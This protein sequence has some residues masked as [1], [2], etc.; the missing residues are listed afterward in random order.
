ML[1][2]SMI[3]LWLFARS[4][5]TPPPAP[6]FDAA[7]QADWASGPV[8]RPAPPPEPKRGV[9]MLVGGGL[10]SVLG[11]SLSATGTVYLGFGTALGPANGLDRVYAV[12]LPLL[13]PGILSVG[14]GATLLAVGGVRYTRWKA[15]RTRT[16]TTLE[17]SAGRSPHG[18]WTLG[19]TLRF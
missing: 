3:P 5:Y 13:V 18:T 4:L 19:L 16:A 1:A 6:V 11:L 15:W 7:E 2:V 9:G 12:S 17:P 14:A 10:L 8:H